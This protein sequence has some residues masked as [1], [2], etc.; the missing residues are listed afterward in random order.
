MSQR[1]AVTILRRF[2]V[3]RV[4]R[5]ALCATAASALFPAISAGQ[6]A[7]PTAA[8][9]TAP[10]AEWPSYMSAF[11]AYVHA[12]SI[13]GAATLVMRDGRVLAHHETGF[14]DRALGQRVDTN[15]I[16]HWGSITKTLTAI[17]VMRDGRVLAH[18]ETGFADRALG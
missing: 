15:T 2:F 10:P 5:V 3:A 18:H 6:S 17:A 13:V 16:F 7:A 11:D 12:D 14:A 9:R 8:S 4:A 1:T